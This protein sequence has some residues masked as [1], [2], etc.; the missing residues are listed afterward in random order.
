MGIYSW[1]E[2]A[3]SWLVGIDVGAAPRADGDDL[4]AKGA[5]YV[6]ADQT[7]HR[8]CRW[9]RWLVIQRPSFL[10][11]TPARNPR[12]HEIC[13]DR[14]RRVESAVDGNKRSSDEATSEKAEEKC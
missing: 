3:G 8:I 13:F 2:L 11:T 14:V 9:G 5:R 10:R 1:E 4:R 12:Q 7:E 6:Q